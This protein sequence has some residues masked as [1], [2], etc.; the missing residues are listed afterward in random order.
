M[1][2]SFNGGGGGGGGGG[3]TPAVAG[4]LLLVSVVLTSPSLSSLLARGE[5]VLL[6][7]GL[8]IFNTTRGVNAGFVGCITCGLVVEGVEGEGD[9]G[10]AGLCALKGLLRNSNEDPLLLAEEEEI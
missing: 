6:L 1:N 7:K 3:L 8:D 5:D 4:Q 10:K 2:C 9:G